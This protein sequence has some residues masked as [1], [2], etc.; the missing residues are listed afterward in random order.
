M[1]SSV[2]N[3]IL[4]GGDTTLGACSTLS[5]QNLNIVDELLSSIPLSTA[6][7]KNINLKVITKA[8]GFGDKDTLSKLIKKL[9]DWGKTGGFRPYKLN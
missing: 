1:N 6:N 8:G 2:S 7:Y 3:L 9:T 5:I 4:T